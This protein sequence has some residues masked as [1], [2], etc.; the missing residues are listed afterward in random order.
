MLV[1]MLA[2][3]L[4]GCAA[5]Y[6]LATASGGTRLYLRLP[7]AREVALA[8]SVDDYRLRPASPGFFGTWAVSVPATGEFE[9]FYI[10]DGK[11]YQ[12]D[13]RYR[14]ADDFGAQNCIHPP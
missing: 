6:D 3:A 13:C 12:P 11:V 5:H 8:A 4:S 1:V 10:V 7:G 2:A 14:Q 9:Y